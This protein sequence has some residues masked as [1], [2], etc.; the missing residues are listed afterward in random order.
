MRWPARPRWTAILVLVAVGA[1]V[2]AGTLGPAVG[3]AAGVR[4]ASPP[5]VV[6]GALTLTGRRDWTRTGRRTC[7]GT[8]LYGDVGSGTSVIVRDPATG[9]VLLKTGLRAGVR[10]GG[11]RFAFVL[12]H[13][14]SAPEYGIVIGPLTN[15]VY[16]DIVSSRDA[17]LTKGGLEFVIG[18]PAPVPA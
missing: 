2:A 6:R 1:A 16:Q 3:A 12:R 18:S 13:L 7:D 5:R 9:R 10:D 11:C 15:I 8:G 4:S 17:R 14:R